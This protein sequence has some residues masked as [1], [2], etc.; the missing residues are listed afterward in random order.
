MQA[1]CVHNEVFPVVSLRSLVLQTRA[2]R[3]PAGK[4]SWCTVDN[5]NTPRV[6][7][8]IYYAP[9]NNMH[10]LIYINTKVHRVI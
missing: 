8:H 4:T 7:L 3:A 10:K 6:D 9:N 5:F 1:T 2:S